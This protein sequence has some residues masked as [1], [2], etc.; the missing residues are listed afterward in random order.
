MN[1]ATPQSIF[2]HL[3]NEPLLEIW[4]WTAEKKLKL[5]LH[6]RAKVGKKQTER[7]VLRVVEKAFPYL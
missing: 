7:F 5:G 2:T 3:K 1:L 4:Q 6:E